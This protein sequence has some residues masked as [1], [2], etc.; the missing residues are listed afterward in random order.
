MGIPSVQAWISDLREVE[1]AER[2]VG[3]HLRRMANKDEPVIEWVRLD[4]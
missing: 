3:D 2:V 1:R 4:A